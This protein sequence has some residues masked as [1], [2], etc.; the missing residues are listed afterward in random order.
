VQ[1]RFWGVRGSIATPEALNL[2]YGGNTTCLELRDPDGHVVIIDSGT[3]VRRLG[4]ALAE[5]FRGR[6]LVVHFLLTHFHLDHIQG[7]PYFAPLFE[8]TTEMIFYSSRPP[9]EVRRI[10]QRQMESPFFPVP[11]GFDTTAACKEFVQIHEKPIRIGG[12]SVQAFPLHHPQGA[13]GYRIE[14]RHVAIVHACDF[15]HGDARLDAVLREHARQA[16]LVIFDAQYT[17]DEYERRRGAGHST[18]LEATR[19]AR[20]AQVKR[21]MLF[22]HDPTHADEVIDAMV[23]KARREFPQTD[24][25]REGAE[26]KW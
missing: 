19:L 10:L 17:P 7:L 12:V 6:R 1:L 24:A 18:W 25:A 11:F 23:E 5:E 13:T 20:D 9:K 4:A 15:E 2:G 26:L 16:D 3:G 14:D 22:H 21:L 8:P